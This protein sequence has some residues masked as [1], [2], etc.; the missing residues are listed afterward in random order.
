MSKDIQQSRKHGKQSLEPTITKGLNEQTHFADHQKESDEVDTIVATSTTSFWSFL[1][2]KNIAIIIGLSLI[3]YA[4]YVYKNKNNQ[5]TQSICSK[6]TS[7]CDVSSNQDMRVHSGDRPHSNKDLE[8]K[9][10]L[11]NEELIETRKVLESNSRAILALREELRSIVDQRFHPRDSANSQSQSQSDMQARPQSK[12]KENKETI[13]LMSI[14]DAQAMTSIDIQALP[15]LSVRKNNNTPIV[16]EIED[17][18]STAEIS[19][20]L[21]ELED[22]MA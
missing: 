16:E 15:Q 7:L 17:E 13:D 18:D 20:E 6:P 3:G 8:T 12:T 11:V 10:L 4:I 14:E 1:N 21:K 19:K 22:N 9:F 2:F 5:S